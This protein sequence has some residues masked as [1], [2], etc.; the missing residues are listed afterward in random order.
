M[1]VDI[2]EGGGK[3]VKL[4][5][6][7]TLIAGGAILVGLGVVWWYHRYS[8]AAAASST[9]TDTTGDGTDGLSDGSFGDVAGGMSG[10]TG[11]GNLAGVQ[12]V[13]YTTNAQW[14]QGAMAALSNVGGM[15]TGA[16]SAALGVYLTGGVPT[17]AQ[18]SLIDQAIAANGYPPVA[19]PGSYPPGIR[20]A[21]PPGQTPPK[22]PPPKNP[23]PKP[24]PTSGTYVVVHGDT[25]TS[26][27]A[28]HHV[29][30]AALEHANPEAG[31]PPGN[32]NL[33]RPGDILHIP[34]S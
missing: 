14:E 6:R 19:G 18:E 12:P 8:A 4:G 34:T 22:N 10:A 28:S 11:A 27:A 29:T 13:A 31:H 32:F 24:K 3:K 20:Q 1:P 30:L 2:P 16:L 5:R 33:I 9:A 17:Q 26:I 15:D 23:P 21:P 7:G 25:M